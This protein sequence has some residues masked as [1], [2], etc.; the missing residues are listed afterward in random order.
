MP[1]LIAIVGPTA[2]GKS[3]LAIE[4]AHTL[5]AEIVSADSMLV[6]KHMNIGTAKPTGDEMRGIPHHMINIVTPDV[7]FTVHDYQRKALTCIQDIIARNKTPLLVG[8]TGLYIQSV[9]DGYEFGPAD[10]NEVY[11]RQLDWIAQEHGNDI[12]YQALRLFDP[13]SAERINPND[14]RRLI[15]ALEVYKATGAP[16]SAQKKK[17]SYL[18]EMDIRTIRIGL[19]M[20]RERLYQ[21][22]D[23]RVDEMMRQ[24]LLDEV[25]NLL[26]LGYS[27]SLYS[28]QSLGYKQITNYLAGQYSLEEAVSE[29][30]RETR[31]FSKRQYTWF[32]RD[33]HIVWFYTDRAESQSSLYANVCE[34]LKDLEF[35]P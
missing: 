31:R 22:I 29:I 30:K 1:S 28:M 13:I 19:T 26:L 6:Y 8:G 24:G 33:P 25:R 4:L 27:P 9:L 7:V 3:K 16:I 15:R 11:R 10:T 5:D 32:R 23:K 2:T 34:I 14:L 20:D 35:G 12:L 18:A 21:R 17:P